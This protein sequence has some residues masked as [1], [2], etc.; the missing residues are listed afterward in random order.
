MQS[1]ETASVSVRM[2]RPLT[3]DLNSAKLRVLTRLPVF[4]ERSLLQ[5]GIAPLKNLLDLALR[6]FSLG[7][8][9][10]L[11]SGGFLF[12]FWVCPYPVWVTWKRRHAF[13]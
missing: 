3:A 12:S 9:H 7:G 6:S 11:I 1:H 2:G 13:L 8:K 10:I 5:V 4:E